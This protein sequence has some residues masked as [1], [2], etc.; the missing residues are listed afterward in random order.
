[1]IERGVIVSIQGYHY[2]TITEL[3]LDAISAGCVALRTD[4]RIMLRDDQRVPVIGLKKVKVEEPKEEPYITQTVEDVEFVHS[5]SD[6]V[7]IDYRRLNP[8]LQQ[9]SRFCREHGVKVVADIETYEDYQNIVD[10]GFLYEY[11]ATTFAVFDSLFKPNL[12]LVEQIA[13]KEKRLIAEGNFSS[14]KD[15]QEAFEYGAACVCIGSAISN[16]YK[17]TKKY[18]SAVPA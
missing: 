4:K 6:L 18:T 12:K 9:L 16:V 10:R 5:W 8:R 17:L 3:A 11:V 15:V 2:R 13:K 14:R 1:M 7:A